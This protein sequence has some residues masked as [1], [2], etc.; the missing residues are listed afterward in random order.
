MDGSNSNNPSNGGGG[1]GGGDA[2]N[3]P[4]QQQPPPLRTPPPPHPGDSSRAVRAELEAQRRANIE[5]QRHY[6]PLVQQQIERVFGDTQPAWY[7]RLRL[8]TP[9]MYAAVAA[10]RVLGLSIQR[11]RLLSDT[12]ARALTEHAARSSDRIALMD[13]S[14]TGVAAYFTWRGRRTL[15][16]PQ[17]VVPPPP[18]A[19][20]RMAMWHGARYVAYS[21]ALTVTVK[22]PL[23][24]LNLMR[25]ARQIRADERLRGLRDDGQDSAAG[26]EWGKAGAAW[27]SESSAYSV[28]PGREDAQQRQR[29]RQRQ[30]QSIQEA[31]Q[32]GWDTSRQTEQSPPLQQQQPRQ[33]GQIP[34]SQG[35]AGWGSSYGQS[36]SSSSSSAGWDSDDFD[37]ASPVAASAQ[38]SSRSGN[39]ASSGSTWERLRQQ[40]RADPQQRQQQQQQVQ[41]QVQQQHWGDA[42]DGADRAAQE[43]AQRDF[44]RLVERDRQG[45][46]SR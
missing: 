14:L 11:D 9:A 23:M 38:L 39:S 30:R 4:T 6:W 45:R 35:S 46:S 41:P 44:D 13:W 32:S 8:F 17:L 1:G 7:A 25:E 29:Q 3:A 12:E 10:N 19:Y 21:A 34:Q 26:G 40:A 20:L 24:A 5:K 31:A 36:P 37:D 42:G 18:G 27:E 2:S 22:T 43:K 16:T 15:W 33:Y 28:S